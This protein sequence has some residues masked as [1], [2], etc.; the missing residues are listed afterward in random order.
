MIG[1][2]Y[3]WGGPVELE[4]NLLQ[5]GGPK[6]ITYKVKDRKVSKNVGSK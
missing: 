4:S 6:K 3:L 1:I 2:E 5:K